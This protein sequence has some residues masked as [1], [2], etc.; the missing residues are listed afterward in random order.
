MAD[1]DVPPI[2]TP[3]FHVRLGQKVY[4][5][6]QEIG[7]S[8]RFLGQL[9]VELM[10]S[11]AHPKRLRLIA[12]ASSIQ[13]AGFDALP[14]IAIMTLFL[15]AVVS[16]IGCDMLTPLGASKQDVELFGMSVR[17]EID[18]RRVVL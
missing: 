7:A 8:A 13:K 3:P 16:L 10:K 15:G 9:E 12:L 2:K 14:L 6:V 1:R 17:R 4:R 5:A 18:R 11:L